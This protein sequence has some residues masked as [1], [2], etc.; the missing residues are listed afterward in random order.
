[1]TKKKLVLE[2]EVKEATEASSTET[3]VKQTAAQLFGGR[4]VVSMSRHEG[5]GHEH[6]RNKVVLKLSD[7]TETIASSE[8]LESVGIEAPAALE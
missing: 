7:N 2:E 8:D 4:E 3:Q 6:L 5:S 1:M